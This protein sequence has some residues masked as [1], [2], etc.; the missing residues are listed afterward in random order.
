MKENGSVITVA[1][2]DAPERKIIPSI[3][4]FHWGREAELEECAYSVTPSRQRVEP[5]GAEGSR[6]GVGPRE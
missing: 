6:S 1:L 4:H 2:L 3:R 5:A